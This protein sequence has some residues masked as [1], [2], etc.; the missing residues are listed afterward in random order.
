MSASPSGPGVLF[1]DGH[2]GMCTRSRDL[3]ERMNRT[4]DVRLEPLQRPDCVERLSEALGRRLADEELMA[5]IWW[6]GDDGRVCAAAEAAAVA[7]SVATG[8][9][10]PRWLY[11]LPGARPLSESAYR[12]VAD[13]RGRFP[14][15]TPYCD[16]EPSNC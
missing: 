4:G 15:T 11:R 8:V 7:A 6:L 9:P 14:G 5:S 13:N 16:R 12:W 3:L 1:F 10:V 2:C